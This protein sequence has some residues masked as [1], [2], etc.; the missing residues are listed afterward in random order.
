V[1]FYRT[2]KIFGILRG[3]VVVKPNLATHGTRRLF[4]RFGGGQVATGSGLLLALGFLT[5]AAAAAF[6]VMLVA[7]VSVLFKHGFLFTSGGYKYT[8][9][10]GVAGLTVAFTELG[11][12]SLD[13]LLGLSVSGGFW[14]VAARCSDP[15][16]SATTGD[17]TRIAEESCR[18][19]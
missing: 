17:A 13:A 8:L 16:R 4:G 19:F 7:G 18:G 14:G 11:S 3:V 12:P 5:P 2:Y 15:I 10:S 1:W 9:V 6:S